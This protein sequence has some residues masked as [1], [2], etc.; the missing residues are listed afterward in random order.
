[1]MQTDVLSGHLHQSGY[2]V[3][4][5]PSR[6]KAVSIKGGANV[7]QFDLFSTTTAPVSA[8]YAQANVTI[9]VSKTAHSLAVGD[10]VGVAFTDGTGGAGFNGNYSV[11]SLANANAFTITSPNPANITAGAVC[12][13]VSG[14]QAS[15]LM[16]FELTAADTY[17]NYFLI[18]GE[19]VRAAL[20]TY[21]L[22][23]NVSVATVFYG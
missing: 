8:T 21:G 4:Q 5:A 9:T 13:Y 20:P 10:R 1:M 18:P 12:N 15:W 23:N 19:G 11:V 2:I 3:L 16:T 6:I 17:Q 14:G 7:A 22:M